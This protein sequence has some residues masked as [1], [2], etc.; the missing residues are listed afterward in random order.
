MVF[1]L[2]T[3]Y[4]FNFSIA[5]L[6][7]FKDKSFI[8]EPSNRGAIHFLIGIHFHEVAL[9]WSELFRHFGDLHFAC[10]DVS[11]LLEAVAD[12]DHLAL[13]TPALPV[14]EIPH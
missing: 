4:I 13:G 9:T 8:I 7:K 12:V 1:Q 11:S 14:V 5:K 6:N 3:I 10:N 2:P